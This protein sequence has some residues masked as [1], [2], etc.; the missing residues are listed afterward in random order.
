MD[1]TPVSEIYDEFEEEVVKFLKENQD[2]F[3]NLDDLPKANYNNI[4]RHTFS[5][6]YKPYRSH[7]V[8][9]DVHW[10]QVLGKLEGLPKEFKSYIDGQDNYL[11]IKTDLPK[12]IYH[13][14]TM[15]ISGE[16]KEELMR[17]V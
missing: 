12:K 15:E 8:F 10:Y 2:E 17:F 14:D 6:V 5:T 13:V 7:I 16:V 3:L 4:L 11:N 9:R 1:T